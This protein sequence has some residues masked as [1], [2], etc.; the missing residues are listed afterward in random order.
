MTKFAFI[1]ALLL[2]TSVSGALPGVIEL[3]TTPEKI[4]DTQLAALLDKRVAEAEVVALGETVHASSG[5][6]K[7][8]TRLIR[9]LVEKHGFRLIV[10]ENPPLRSLEL[11]RW[12]SSCTTSK[13]PPPIDVLYLPTPSDYPLWEWVCDFNRANP[14][15]TI[16][17][18]GMDVWDRPW[19]H[20][21]RIRTLAAGVGIDRRVFEDIEKL[22]PAYRASSWADI[23]VVLAQVQSDRHFSS[24]DDYEKCRAALTSLVKAARQ[25]GLDR[26]KKKDSAADDAFELAISASTL[27][28]W[29]GFYNYNWSDDVPSWNARD[30]AQGRNTMLIMEKHAVARAIVAAHTSHVSHNRSRAD[31]WGFGDIKSGIHFFT[32]MTR[33][34]VF[35]IAFT[36]YEA[37]GAQGQ[38]LLPAAA[39]SLDRK[40]HDAKHSFA[41]F[42][43]DAAFLSEHP[44][45]WI[46]NQNAGS[47]ENGVELVPRDHFDAFIFLHR[48]HLD[49]ALPARPMWE[50]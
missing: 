50:P 9:Y 44:R 21:A 32:A 42:T 18:R 49:R 28:G 29:L 38:W 34:K 45:W 15:D 40:L 48:S 1:A 13:S 6:L 39:N 35:N 20:Y 30:E 41:F 8:Q 2:S 24:R 14:K 27:L 16:A 43:S 11:A 12:V 19:E 7:I 31:W 4:T 26:Q 47:Y 46:Q 33:K 36:A 17:F 3:G 23:E 25:S 10:W 37:S 5:F 22:C